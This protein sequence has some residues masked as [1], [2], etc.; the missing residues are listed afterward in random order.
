MV[1]I[2][3]TGQQ[4]ADFLAGLLGR[5]HAETG[6]QV[7]GWLLADWQAALQRLRRVMPRDYKRVLAATRRA[8]RD[9]QDVAA[10]VMAA[11]RG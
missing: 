11:A 5:Y 2:E 7:A 10:A 6:S 8:R 1:D 3:P 4:D 9:G